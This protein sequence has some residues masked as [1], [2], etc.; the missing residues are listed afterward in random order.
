MQRP[1]KAGFIKVACEASLAESPLGLLEAAAQAARSSD[2]AIEVH[3]EKGADAE[4]ILRFF[5][6]HGVPAQR[7]VICHIDKRPDLG[8]HRELA[9][10]GV[11]LEYDTFFRP[12]YQPEKNVW[13]LLEGMVRG[14]LAGS[15]ALATDLA[16]EAL[17]LTAG[18]GP[19]LAGL[20]TEVRPRL[21]GLGFDASTVRALTG[22]NIAERLSRRPAW[23]NEIL[24]GPEFPDIPIDGGF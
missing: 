23:R 13:P 4:A 10:E 22:L 14:G 12:K 18:A 2:A 5:D 19:G 8:L 1:V 20:L 6:E 3:T 16:D 24:R 9:R 17:W 7:L 15:V 21:Y 11:L